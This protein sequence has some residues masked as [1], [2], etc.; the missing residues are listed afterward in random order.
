MKTDPN[1]IQ[2]RR[3]R[4]HF[5]NHRA[6]AGEAALRE[7]EH[8]YEQLSEVM[9]LRQI[10]S[11]MVVH[12]LRTPLTS[13]L[14]GLEAA[15]CL[16]SL[17]PEQS[18]C[19]ETAIGGGQALLGM[20]NDLLEICRMEDCALALEPAAVDVPSLVQSALSQVAPLAQSKGLQL[21][22]GVA[23]GMPALWGDED[24]LE[25][26]LVNLLGNAVKFTPE[27]GV[28]STAAWFVPRPER[29]DA[30]VLSVSDTGEGIPLEARGKI[31]D[32]FGQVHARR[33]GHVASTGLGLTF[34]KMVVEAHGGRIWV[35]S[36]L[37]CGSTFAL[38]IPAH[39]V[40]A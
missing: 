4:R 31:F 11:Q 21:C 27:G 22:L 10:L 3:A 18:E 37:G 33:A 7:A 38:A 25:R 35:D 19:I 40:A 16:S 8:K 9:S 1:S 14:A 39:Q 20:V 17:T 28:V 24:K 23:P 26:A 34:C 29:R 12:D 6:L 2:S 32:K 13:L 30:F 36:E 15:E 5:K